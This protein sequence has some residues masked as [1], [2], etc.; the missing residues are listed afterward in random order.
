MDYRYRIK[1]WYLLLNII[2]AL[3]TLSGLA[4]LA[5]VIIFFVILIVFAFQ[6][7]EARNVITLGMFSGLLVLF[8]ALMA[9]VGV[10]FPLGN[11]LFSYLGIKST[12]L[13]LRIWPFYRLRCHWHHVIGIERV[14]LLGGVL[15]LP[16]LR[17]EEG[18]S[19]SWFGKYRLGGGHHTSFE[20]NPAVLTLFLV[21]LLWWSVSDRKLIPVYIF[22]GWPNGQLKRDLESRLGPISAM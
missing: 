4:A 1:G 17:F 8:G 9:L 14:R 15:S 21:A 20:E 10:V 19:E 7:G 5:G 3:I 12:G 16:M 18:E 6:N 2:V 22:N 13:E 11:A